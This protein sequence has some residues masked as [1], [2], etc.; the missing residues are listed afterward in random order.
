L[1]PESTKELEI[2]TLNAPTAVV[3]VNTMSK[4]AEN[5]FDETV[6]I[7]RVEFADSSA[8]QRKDW[9]YDEVKLTAKPS[10]DSKKLQPCRGL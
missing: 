7:N 5:A 8:W 4:K 2:F 6:I 1:K 9:V 10:S 3:T